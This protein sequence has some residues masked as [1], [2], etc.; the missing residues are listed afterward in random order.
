M[1]SMLTG[2]TTIS[3]GD[4]FLGGMS[5]LRGAAG[6]R[7]HL[8]GYCPQFDALIDQMTVRETLWMYA[9]LR[10]IHAADIGRVV[11]KLVDQL[12]LEKYGDREAGKLRYTCSPSSVCMKCRRR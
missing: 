1:F 10:G 9:R 2:D 7:K 11:D 4:A 8:V 12:T 6:A 3:S 5:V